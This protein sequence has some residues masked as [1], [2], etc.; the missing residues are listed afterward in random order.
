MNGK[1]ADNRGIALIVVLLAVTVIVAFTVEFNRSARSDIY[2]AAN[3][4]DRIALLYAAKSGL[5]LGQVQL[6]DDTNDFD[7]LT[8][9]WAKPLEEKDV[10]NAEIS[11]TIEDESG[12]IPVNLL[13][14]GNAYNPEIQQM[15]VRL[16]SLPEFGLSPERVE[17]VIASLKDW[18]DSDSEVTAGGAESDYYLRLPMPYSCKN[19]PLDRLEELLM[20]KGITKELYYGTGDTPGIVRCLT[21]YGKGK[22]NINTA[23]RMVLQALGKDVTASMA[24][25]LD[26]YR[27]SPGSNLG[28]PDW[29]R[30]VGGWS[31]ASIK[32]ELTTIKSDYYGITVSCALGAMRER[33]S[34]VVKRNQEQKK[35]SLLS[36]EAD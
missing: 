28:S 32:S 6:M 1:F 35:I 7:A 21:V 18:I 26:E 2:D 23:P 20:V 5:A 33:V 29:F 27:R 36:W 11:V 25:Q 10:N 13:V 14:S 12:K 8:E 3:F 22:I 9:D 16:L 30:N 31:G 34:G 17:E 19:A 15:L 24:E 4:R